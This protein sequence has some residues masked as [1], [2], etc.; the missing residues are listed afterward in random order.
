MQ[1]T[2]AC[3]LVFRSAHTTLYACGAQPAKTVKIA[4]A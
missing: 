2:F 1:V 4:A 3:F